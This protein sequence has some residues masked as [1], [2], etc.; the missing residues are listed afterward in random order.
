MPKK[1]SYEEF[2]RRAIDSLRE[3]EYKGIHSCVFRI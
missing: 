2:V 1:S 3:E